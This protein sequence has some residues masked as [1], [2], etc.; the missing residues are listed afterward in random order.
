MMAR[1][2]KSKVV[3]R[4]GQHAEGE[5]LAREAVELAG[6]TQNL[7]GQ[8]DA[9]ADLGEVLA[10]AGRPREAA[11]AYGEALARYERKGDVVS[12]G[13]ARRARQELLP[14]SA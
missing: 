12:A 6:R 7:S 9:Y 10:L 2:V 4:R 13:R 8:A 11:G 14:A 5:R 3:A 1:Q